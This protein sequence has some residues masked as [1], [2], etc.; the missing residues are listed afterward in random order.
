VAADQLL[1]D[2]RERPAVVAGY[3]WFGEWSRDTLTSYEGLVLET[4]RAGEGRLLLQRAAASLSEGML[5]N[6]TPGHPLTRAATTPAADG[7]ATITLTADHLVTDGLVTLTARSP[8]QAC[9]ATPRRTRAAHPHLPAPLNAPHRDT[10]QPFTNPLATASAR[11][12]DGPMVTEAR[13]QSPGRRNAAYPAEMLIVRLRAS[14][15]R[16]PCRGKTLVLLLEKHPEIAGDVVH[17]V[18]RCL[19]ACQPVSPVRPRRTAPAPHLVTFP[20]TQKAL[21]VIGK[22]LELRKLVAGAGF[23]PATSGL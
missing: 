9:H 13:R 20:V 16:R 6:T 8:G 3:P 5:A 14:P 10:E 22:G 15:K 7:T 11:H 12:R 21:S 23:E 18:P 17:R 19:A 2:G 4:G 1:I